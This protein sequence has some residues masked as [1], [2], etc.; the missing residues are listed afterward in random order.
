MDGTPNPNYGRPYI[1]SSGYAQAKIREREA[2]QAIGFAKYD[3]RDKH[4]GLLRHFGR[5]ALTAVYQD[6]KNEET[7]PNRQ[8]A[9]AGSDWKSIIGQADNPRVAAFPQRTQIHQYLGPSMVN[10][11]SIDDVE[12][13]PVTVAQ[14]FVSTDNALK[15]NPETGQ[16]E[17]G[18]VLV[19]SAMNDPEQV[20]TW[21]NPGNRD[22][23][24]S[25]STVL[26]SHFLND[27]IVTTVSWRKDDVK[28]F[29]GA[30]LP[31]PATSLYGFDHPIV[32]G[33]ALFDDSVQQRSYGIVG[34]L[35]D[36][37]L[38]DG[39][40]LSVH[41]VDSSNFAA[42]TAGNDIFNRPAP[43]QSGTTEEYGFSFSA[44]DGQFYARV[45]F[46]ETLQDWVKITGVLPQIGLTIVSVME[47]NTPEALEAAGWSLTDGSLFNPDTIKALNIRN[48]G[49]TW[50]A[51]NIAGT[52]TNYYQNTASDGMEI[53]VSYAPKSNWR[54][55]FNV[56]KVE[57]YLNNVMP[58]AGPELTRIAN[59][60]F[61]DPV[62][63]N[64]FT[65]PSPTQ[66]PDGSYVESGLLRSAAD[67]LLSQIAIKKG[68]ENGPSQELRKWRANLVTN[69]TFSDNSFL[70][71]FGVGTGI[72]W[73]DK[74]AIG[75]GLKEVAG[76]IVPDWDNPYYGPSEIAV[77]AWI[78]YTTVVME[79][80]DLHL[81]LR[82]R[83]LT[84]GSG[85][86][87][88]IKANPDGEV[89]LWRFGAPA[90]VEFSAGLRF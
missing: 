16:F 5:H 88:P 43:L 21:G 25:V 60:V 77:D 51:D 86:Y 7:A 17:A 28:T 81:Q 70:A 37:W 73:Q 9:R 26:Q 53:E 57:A 54:I 27:N 44:L 41:Y 40:G 35:P 64:L 13:H 58:I 24:S 72:R 79:D 89:A 68:P 15:W 84:D 32:Y 62:I 71:G 18:S 31:D 83:N 39:L 36:R 6:Q 30:A 4:D 55:H 67:G 33:D 3:F 20:W 56:A 46:F 34:H 8:N 80:K 29:T 87:I 74:V 48:E 22:E 1:G 61:R 49:G 38:P 76:E 12:I 78:N 82:F 2:S 14:P 66:N 10:V 90:Y 50:F 19:Y 59:E 65:T 11:S 85:E 52:A 23:I 69:Y 47:N 63:G 42:G 45:N 75:S